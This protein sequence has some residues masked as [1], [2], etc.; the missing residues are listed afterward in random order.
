MNHDKNNGIFYTPPEL[1]KFVAKLGISSINS[2]VLDPCYG[3][4][5]LLLAAQNRLL[6]HNS[7]ILNRQLYGYDIAPPRNKGKKISLKGLLS[8]KNLK[9]RDFFSEDDKDL[10]LKFDVILMN[11]PFVRHHLIP[12]E[13]QK[14]I[15]K[16]IGDYKILPMTSDLWAYF[17]VHSL[18]FLRTGGNLVAI[19]PWS[20]LHADFAIRVRRIILDKFREL[21]VVVIGKRIFKKVEER[22]LVLTGKEFGYSTSEIG[23]SYSPCIPEDKISWK[24]ISREIWQNSLWRSFATADIHKILSEININPG[25]KPLSHF[26][27]VRIGTVTGANNFFIL[28]KDDAKR[29]ILPKRIL[30]PIIR[31]SGDLRKLVISSSDNIQDF[32]LLIPENMKL[33]PPLKA[34]IETG[35]NKHINKRCHSLKRKKWYSIKNQIPPDGFFHYM[36]KEMPFIVFN[37]DGILSTNTIHNLDFLD[38]VDENTKKWIQF[39]MLTSISQLSI[40]LL[41]RTYGGGVLK[42]EPT[43]ANKILVY[44]G[45]GDR[46]PADLENDLNRLLIDGKHREAMKHADRWMVNNSLI[47]KKQMNS[48][49]ACYE[50]LRDLRLGDSS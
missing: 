23:I 6:E 9:D 31:R 36:T 35:K 12:K 43:A 38:A 39:S 17:L 44:P 8:Q 2:R 49:K 10:K 42:I 41:G 1:A 28:K 16:I 29:M 46:F 24:Q 5:A 13:T 14:R 26:A 47:T 15:R 37:P 3:E 11:P 30:K 4:G 50:N 45:N 19:L 27:R 20:F 7:K 25:Y 32:L 34:Y 33:P 21:Q 22:V 48:I 40:E 18:K